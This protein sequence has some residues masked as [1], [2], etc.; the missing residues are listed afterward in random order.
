[1]IGI[2]KTSHRGATLSDTA[3][4]T[5]AEIVAYDRTPQAKKFES[6]HREDKKLSVSLL[7]FNG[8]Q[9]L[10]DQH[11]VA[12]VEF[13]QG[14]TIAII[15]C[16]TFVPE[17]IPVL[18]RLEMLSRQQKPFNDLQLLNIGP[19][20][21]NNAV[22]VDNSFG[23]IQ[24][25]Q[26]PPGEVSASRG[27]IQTSICELVKESKLEPLI[28]I[29]RD[30]EALSIL[31]SKLAELAREVKLDDGQFQS[32]ISSLLHPVHCT[33]GPPGTGKSYLGVVI[34]R[35][36]L[37]IRK[38]WILVNPS[39]GS[40]PVLI[41]SY[42]NHAID[43]LTVDLVNAQQNVKLVRIGRSDDERLAYYNE[44]CRTNEDPGVV[45]CLKRLKTIHNLKDIL[46]ALIETRS[47]LT[48]S[49]YDF[50]YVDDDKTLYDKTEC[51]S[52]AI[53]SLNMIFQV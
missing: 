15:D 32:F 10:G 50:A 31:V 35:A 12:K 4:I 25:Q 11:L 16:M 14:D 26:E 41:L 36:L 47:N 40:P 49:K 39:V 8:S 33:Q 45:E 27:R 21:D 34:T 5:W 18:M 22:D 37:I 20:A 52:N 30:P 28:Q 53:T 38:L 24:L 3:L 7:N 13:K 44:R 17:Q 43:E 46:P 29:R 9:G 42:K 51:L 2:I 6:K 23:E 48:L 1:M 19:N